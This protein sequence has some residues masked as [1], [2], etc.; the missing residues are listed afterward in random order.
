MNW[1]EWRSGLEQQPVAPGFVVRTQE[2]R[3]E[4]DYEERTMEFGEDL[5]TPAEREEEL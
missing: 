2:S 1:N 3:S 4:G 5:E